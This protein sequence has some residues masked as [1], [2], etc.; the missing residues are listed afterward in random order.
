MKTNPHLM[1]TGAIKGF[2]KAMTFDREKHLTNVALVALSDDELNRL[3]ASVNKKH[4]APA[5]Q[6]KPDMPIAFG[7]ML[8]LME[9]LVPNPIPESIRRLG[10]A[11]CMQ[12]EIYLS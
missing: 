10:F 6:T 7:L 2:G 5:N 1:I 11:G 3:S 12:R 9:K 8:R 4:R